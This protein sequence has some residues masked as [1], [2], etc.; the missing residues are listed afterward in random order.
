MATEVPSDSLAPG[1]LAP[2]ARARK[3]GRV[4][5]GHRGVGPVVALGFAAWLLVGLPFPELSGGLW[6][7]ALGAAAVAQGAW[8][9]AGAIAGGM[10]LGQLTGTGAA[11]KELGILLA[12]AL[13]QA[14]FF[15]RGRDQ[16]RIIAWQVA[17][18][19]LLQGLAGLPGAAGAP[20]GLEA[21][22]IIAWP[23]LALTTTFLLWLPLINPAG[24]AR[25]APDLG[26]AVVLTLCTGALW[27][28]PGAL[29]QPAWLAAAFLVQGAALAA[30]AGAGAGMGLAIGALWFW[31]QGFPPGW[32]SILGLA[33]LLGGLVRPLGR[34]GVVAGSWLGLLV[35]TPQI[36]DPATLDQLLVSAGLATILLLL[37]PKPVL[38]RWQG[39]WGDGEVAAS[40]A[41]LRAEVGADLRK[42][43]R[44]YER[45]A[46]Q[47]EPAGLAQPD[48]EVGLFIQAVHTTACQGC[49]AHERCWGREM[50]ATYWGMVELVGALESFAKAPTAEALPRRLALRCTRHD[51]LL[52][53]ISQTLPRFQA[54]RPTAT[55]DQGEILLPEQFRALA[56]LVE[57]MA[58]RV[59]DRNQ[60]ADEVERALRQSLAQVAAVKSLRCTRVGP[61]RY[62]VV[63]QLRGGCPE[64][65]FCEKVIAPLVSRRLGRPY[66][67]WSTTCTGSAGT[68]CRFELVARRRFSLEVADASVQREGELHSGDSVD[69]TE[70]VDGR[71]AVVL[72]DGMGSGL[73]AWQESRTAVTLLRSLLEVGLGLEHSVRLVNSLLRARSAQVR[74][75]TLDML[76][77]DLYTGQAQLLKIGAAPSLVVRRGE[78]EIVEG[79]SPP[80]GVVEDLEADVQTIALGPDDRVVLASDGLW[81]AGET[82]QPGWLVEEVSRFRAEEPAVLAEILAARAR[83]LRPRGLHDDATVLIAR[84]KPVTTAGR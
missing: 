53:G 18:L 47:L 78:V 26:L 36:A 15:S 57:S 77:V 41:E 66:A 65:G 84:L 45:I 44:L 6:A 67:V 1:S 42:V 8:P 55:G 27:R 43:S 30:G 59:E 5:F 81:E 35:T 58:T 24:H 46:R 73:P 31:S 54:A 3:G 34:P 17:A 19:A 48:E 16:R 49:P 20:S 70:L 37:V 13:T 68:G 60:N 39:V 74:F 29:V 56:G 33:G 50:Y 72:S 51:R 25:H 14:A 52:K 32:A 22:K 61:N 28:W 83:E 38:R 63:G 69:R 11:L 79:E 80:A 2:L 75:A 7:A 12:F 4:R 10:L 64:P 23:S 76:V 40:A 9:R 82:H 62:R 71:V 21:F